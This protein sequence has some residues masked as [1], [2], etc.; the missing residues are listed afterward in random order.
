[1]K[2]IFIISM[3]ILSSLQLSL[4]FGNR[5]RSFKRSYTDDFSDRR[6]FRNRRDFLD[7]RNFRNRRDFTESRDYTDRRDFTSRGILTRIRNFCR[8]EDCAMNR[9]GR[10][11]KKVLNIN[12]RISGIFSNRERGI[13]RRESPKIIHKTTII[14]TGTH[15]HSKN[16]TIIINK[17]KK[18]EKK[19]YSEEKIIKGHHHHRENN[20]TSNNQG[21]TE[22]NYFN[23]KP[24]NIS[25]I[26]QIINIS[27]PSEKTS[28]INFA[29][30]KNISKTYIKESDENYDSNLNN[31]FSPFNNYNNYN[32]SKSYYSKKKFQ[33]PF[34]SDKYIGGKN[35]FG[36]IGNFNEDYEFRGNEIN[37]NNRSFENKK[38][39]GFRNSGVYGGCAKSV[40]LVGSKY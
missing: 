27:I 7:R 24:S 39:S 21:F 11:I 22:R 37:G 16:K 10:K 3:I 12:G 38:C 36:R 14:K 5:D 32:N 2:K 25:P 40:H 18:I 13:Q 15:D 9:V 4:A 33:G 26:K 34:R 28:P 23:P 35:S 19:S 8:G 29:S 31:N 6:N 30:Q 17:N 1:M 20:Y